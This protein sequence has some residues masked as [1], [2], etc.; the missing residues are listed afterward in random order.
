MAGHNVCIHCKQPHMAGHNVCIHCKQPHMAGHNVCIHCK[1]PYMAGHNVCIHCKQP[2]MAGHIEC[3]KHQR[4]TLIC[5]IQQKEKIYRLRAVQMIYNKSEALQVQTNK[6]AT[7]FTCTMSEG[8]KRKMNPSLL[9]KYIKQQID[10][11]PIKIQT[12]G[13]NS[14]ITQV[15]SEEQ[16]RKI[17]N[18]K[19]INNINVEMTENQFIN[20]SKGIVYIYDYDL[21]N[22]ELL[23]CGLKQSKIIGNVEILYLKLYL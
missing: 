16:C 2:H 8:D 17:M 7:H 1:Q 5:Q 11:S 20:T 13:K 18:I 3:Q 14:Y 15:D 19:Q 22:F 12:S 4:E 21:T 10:K 23:R 9:E 6:F